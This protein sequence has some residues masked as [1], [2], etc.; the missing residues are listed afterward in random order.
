[1]FCQNCGSPV[2][3][4]TKFCANCG[5]AITPASPPPQTAPPQP[6]EQPQAATP[7]PAPVQVQQPV[8]Q[9]VTAPAGQ[10]PEKVK[11]EKVK[12]EKAPKAKKSKARVIVPVVAVTTVAAL[13]VGGF[14][15]FNSTKTKK[16]RE[17]YNQLCDM[18]TLGTQS[19]LYARVLTERILEADVV[20]TDPDEMNKLFDECI[21]AWEATGAVTEDMTSMAEDLQDSSDT[22]RL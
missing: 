18:T 7:Q 12:K 14:F 22:Q 13:G 15:F 11:K 6:V 8:Q 5:A 21:E 10:K 17:S 16:V 2:N 3:E 1:M 9:P 19:Y 20:T 4:N